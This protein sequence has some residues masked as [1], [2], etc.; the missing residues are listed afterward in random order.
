MPILLWVIYPYAV[1]SG[2]CESLA[3]AL[4]SSSMSDPTAMAPVSE[5]RPRYRQRAGEQPRRVP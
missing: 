4:N 3:Q 5:Q 1:W 2:L